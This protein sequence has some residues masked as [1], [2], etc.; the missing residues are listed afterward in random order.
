MTLEKLIN[1]NTDLLNDTDLIICKYILAHKAQCSKISIDDL[2]K[3]C[4]VSKTTIMR[5]TKKLSL[6]GFSHLKIILKE[7]LRKKNPTPDDISLKDMLCR[8]ISRDMDDINFDRINKMIYEANRIFIY[9]S[10]HVQKNIVNEILRLFV[11]A[12][13]HM[14]EIKGP[15]ECNI[16]MKNLRRNDLFIIVSLSG[17]TKSVIEIAEKLHMYKIPIISIV[18]LKDTS[19]AQLSDEN[20]YVKPLVL[21]TGLTTEYTSMAGFFLMIELWFISYTKYCANRNINNNYD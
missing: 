18:K 12:D 9:A 20:I 7:E 1:N 19:L 8:Y 5:F 6:D 15:D 14:F 10:G 16:M 2:A 21:P 4:N 11:Y 17:E 13:V 3:A